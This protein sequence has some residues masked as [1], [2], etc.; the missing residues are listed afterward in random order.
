[1][2]DPALPGLPNL[3]SFPSPGV[4]S[5]LPQMPDIS[6]LQDGLQDAIDEIEIPTPPS[7]ADTGNFFIGTINRLA[8]KL[9]LPNML[10]NLPSPPP[11]PPLPPGLPAVPQLPKL[12][13]TFKLPF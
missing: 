5:G 1:M 12:A 4:N 2:S 8:N 13:R 10:P 6:T 9:G 11:L 3:P 7:V